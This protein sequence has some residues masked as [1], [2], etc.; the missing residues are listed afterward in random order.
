[1]CAA[2]AGAAWNAPAGAQL[3]SVP[4]GFGITVTADSLPPNTLGIAVAP[5]GFG[6]FGGEIFVADNFTHRVLRVGRFGD[7]H[8]FANGILAP[9]NL[10]F[11]P[12]GVF[13]TDLYLSCNQDPDALSYGAVW[14]ISPTGTVAHYG[15]QTPPDPPAFQFGAGGIA[16]S[17]A[18]PFGSF[19][20][21]G[22]S[23]G[24]LG[25]CI[26]RIDTGTGETT[27][28]NIL[29]GGAVISNGAPAGLQFGPGRAGFSTDLYF[30]Y[31]NSP[32]P[33]GLSSAVYTLDSNGQ[34][35]MLAAIDHP[36]EIEFGPGG[37]FG[38]DLYVAAFSG[39]IVRI[40]SG[41]VVS[42][43][44]AGIPGGVFGLA[45]A[46]SSILYFN[47]FDDHGKGRLYRVFPNALL[48]A[49]PGPS[50]GGIALRGTPNPSRGALTFTWAAAGPAELAIYRA[51]GRLVRRLG[52]AREGATWDG[53]DDAGRRAASG[54]YFGVLRAG[55]TRAVCRIALIR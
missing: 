48:P 37:A 55:E 25:D 38:R 17:A 12:G 1:L 40:T 24:N 43:F 7:V 21:T 15:T 53:V 49:P 36:E 30:A 27:A 26:S 51:D 6:A 39:D 11:A 8:D 35:T 45:F 3:P 44:V 5:A 28:F 54:V 20:Y 4:A 31:D 14:R 52:R 50:S 13:G 46:D 33:P 18:G 9:D 16:F 22:A 47:S 2:L 19:L 23:G 41:G 34:R 10:S 42:T 29:P 32:G